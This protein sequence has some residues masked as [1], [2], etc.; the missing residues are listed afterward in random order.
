MSA[1]V[2]Y[3]SYD[4]IECNIV[5]VIASFDTEGRIRPLY[6]RIGEESLKI[7][8]SWLKPSYPGFFEFRCQ[9]IDNG[10]RK[11]LILEYHSRENVWIIP[12]DVYS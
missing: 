4:H 7:L 1:H 9:V 8:S 3:T 5:S 6:V 2:S 11:P 12:K 10:V